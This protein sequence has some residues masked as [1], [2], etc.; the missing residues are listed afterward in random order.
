MTDLSLAQLHISGYY[1]IS[2]TTVDINTLDINKTKIMYDGYLV[3]SV[4]AATDAFISPLA[5]IELLNKNF[6]FPVPRGNF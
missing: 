2:K 1:Y 6:L 4:S 3:V 5:N